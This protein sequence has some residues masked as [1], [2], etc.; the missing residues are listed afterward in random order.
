MLPRENGEDG[1]GLDS[2]DWCERR[3]EEILGEVATKKAKGGSLGFNER[4]VC[5]YAPLLR[6][7]SDA[8]A[9]I[10]AVH[11]AHTPCATAKASLNLIQGVVKYHKESHSVVDAKFRLSPRPGDPLGENSCDSIIIGL[12]ENASP[13]ATLGMQSSTDEPLLVS[14]IL[15]GADVPMR[16]IAAFQSAPETFFAIHDL[17][18]E[19]RLDVLNSMHHLGVPVLD[20][21][22]F[23]RNAS[24]ANKKPKKEAE[25]K[26]K[27][28]KKLTP[29]AEENLLALAK[30]RELA[31]NTLLRA[32]EAGPEE[33]I[34]DMISLVAD[35][36]THPSAQT[37]TCKTCGI[38]LREE[39]S[40]GDNQGPTCKKKAIMAFR[41][42]FLAARQAKE[43]A[44]TFDAASVPLGD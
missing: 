7:R 1:E 36:V 5:C 37:S 25:E 11:D 40:V 6:V 34:F 38:L 26:P 32:I 17:S 4:V 8:T 20:Q 41:A 43:A 16:R 9:A 22:N 27:K 21:A 13:Y 18:P 12:D 23:L 24:E 3:F 30:Q 19:E 29:E 15:P 10:L 42:A 31:A 2:P 39:G 28:K 33:P 35:F 44:Q 14:E